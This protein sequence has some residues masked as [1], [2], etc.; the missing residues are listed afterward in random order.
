MRRISI[1]HERLMR[2]STDCV[3]SALHSDD[4]IEH[5]IVSRLLESPAIFRIWGEPEPFRTVMREVCK[6]RLLAYTRRPLLKKATFRT[7]SSPKRRCSNTC[8]TSVFGVAR[9]SASS[10][11]SIRRRITREQSLRSTKCTFAK[12]CTGFLCTSHVGVNVVAR[13]LLF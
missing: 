1:D 10:S 3:D 13:P 6:H 9:A 5:L 12:A 11:L 7:D 8:A 2:E 4:P